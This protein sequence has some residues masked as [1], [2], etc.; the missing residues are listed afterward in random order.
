MK[1]VDRQGCVALAFGWATAA[2]T[3]FAQGMPAQI[4]TPDTVPSSIGT[5]TYK[6]G[7]PSKE[8]VAKA[9]DYLDLMHGVEAFVNAYQGASVAAIFKGAQEA[10]VPNNIALIFSELM[11][12]KSLFLTANADTI[13]FFVNLD[14]SKGPVVVETPPRVLGVVDDMWF[15][16]ITDFGLPGPDRGEGGKYLFV[17]PDYKGELPGSGFFVQKM[18]TTR[19]T[20][21]G[22]AFLEQND[23]KLSGGRCSAASRVMGSTAL[24][25][26]R[27]ALCG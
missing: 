11:D 22:R 17:P 5:L 18:R 16:W 27:C 8:T 26:P 6:D 14:V 9:Y 15:Q 1:L 4:A 19:A 21:L 23:P 13:Y 12:A 2:S 3:V 20:L 24:P 10:G 25:A 7:A